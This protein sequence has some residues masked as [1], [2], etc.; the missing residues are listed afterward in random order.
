[1]N[2]VVTGGAGFIGANLCRALAARGDRV[3]ALDDLSTGYAVNLSGSGAEL[4]CGS[5]LDRDLLGDTVALADAV[6]HL[7]ALLSVPR[8]LENPLAFHD[9]NATG[10]LNVLEA[11]RP[12]GA[13]VIL[14]SSSAVYGGTEAPLRHE[15]LPPRPLSPYG[16]SK[17]AAESYALAYA[18]SF[19]VPVL[20]FRLFNVYGP[21]Q[22]AGHAHAAVV[23]ALIDAALR[24]EALQIHG[25]G[26]QTR[27]FTN[28]ATVVTAVID[29]LDR[30]TTSA[31]PVNL[32]FGTRTSLLDLVVHLETLLDRPLEIVHTRPK[33]EDLR[34][35][36]A[37]G[38]RLR[39]LF[40]HLTPV[41]LHEGLRQTLAWFRS[42]SLPA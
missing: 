14:A 21:L 33:S 34:A 2:I 26:R 39:S 20:P 4:V 25:D 6:V 15:D 11:A 40:P 35:S 29:A 42:A 8:S 30:G 10:T 17:L 31:T 13:H 37:G 38:D 18:H 27:D 22:S 1:M 32:A 3:T 36:R 5:I 24:G 16:A 12:S 28:V 9:V 23:P 7:A 19:D 41:P